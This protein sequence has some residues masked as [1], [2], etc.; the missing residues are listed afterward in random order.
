MKPL[1]IA[2]VGPLPPPAGGMA[3]LTEELEELLTSSGLEVELIRTNPSYR[4]KFISRIKGVRALFRLCGYLSKIYK[5]CSNVD[6]FHVM[7][8]SGLSWHLFSA[9]VLWLAWIRRVPVVLHYHGGEA[10]KFFS[11]SWFLIKPSMV[12]A[13]LVIV[14]SKFLSKVFS[15][16]NIHSEIVPNVVDIERFQ[17]KDVP[18]FGINTKK[19]FPQIIVVRNLE[20]IYD[21]KTAIQAFALINLQ[22]PTA[23]LTIAG[24]GPEEQALK[25]EV[26]RL[27]ITEETNFCG[28]LNY[29]EIINLYMGA[30]VMINSSLVDNSPV[31]IVEAFASGVPVVSTNV[32]GIPYLIKPEINGM[33]VEP[34][35]PRMLADAVLNILEDSELRKELIEQG[36]KDAKKFDKN[37]VVP[38]IL[39]LYEEVLL[40]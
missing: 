25:R 22:Y 2:L 11:K 40:S 17:M 1:K 27:D 21:I 36:K 3:R 35:D 19:S 33:L 38:Q 8:N 24:S 13:S 29:K 15:G 23:R 39:S 37:V 34:N 12:K 31:S 32:G 26:A 4:P 14:P 28:R 20:K 30:D 18:T 7:A 9:P 6:L 16:R 10:E 5:S